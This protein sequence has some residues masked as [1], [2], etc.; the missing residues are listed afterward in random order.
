M[1]GK[2]DLHMDLRLRVRPSRRGRLV[3]QTVES[4]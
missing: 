4:R 3:T 2:K 1:A